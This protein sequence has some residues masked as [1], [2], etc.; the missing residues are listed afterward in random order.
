MSVQSSIHKYKVTEVRVDYKRGLFT[1]PWG[2]LNELK[3]DIKCIS[4]DLKTFF[5]FP[6]EKTAAT[7]VFHLSLLLGFY[8]FNYTI[9]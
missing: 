8:I 7:S 6:A 1:Y 5:V 2:G 9:V 4:D 3:V